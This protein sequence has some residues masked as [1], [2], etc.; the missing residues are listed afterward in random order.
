MILEIRE[1]QERV[2]SELPLLVSELQVVTG[3]FGDEEKDAWRNSLPLLAKALSSPGFAN[4][5]LYFNGSGALSLEYQLPAASSWCDVVLLGKKAGK[6]GA[7]IIELKHWITHSD[8]PGQVEGLVQH[9]GQPTLHPSDQVRGY[10]EYC[11]RFHSAIHDFEA[12][13]GGCVLFTKDTI[14][15]AYNEQPNEKLVAQFPCFTLSKE[16]LSTPFPEFIA[17]V[18]DEPDPNFAAAFETGTYKQDRGFVRQ[19]GEQIL[20]PQSS[21][22]ELLDNQRRAFALCQAQVHSSVFAPSKGNAKKVVVIEGPPG[23]GKSVVAAKIW[24]SLATNELLPEGSIVFTSTSASQNSNWAHLFNGTA[25]TVAGQGVVKKATSYTPI[26]T[27]ELDRLRKRYAD[28]ELFKDGAA[29]RDHLATLRNLGVRFAEG[30][31]D[32]EYLV[33]VVDEA[34]A[35]INPEHPEGRGQY[36]F[37]TGLGPQAYH[38]MRTSRISIFLLDGEQSFRTQENTTMGDLKQWAKELDADYSHVSLAGSQFRCAGSKEYVDWLEA[39]LEGQNPEICRVLSSAWYRVERHPVAVQ[40]TNVVEFPGSGS[41]WSATSR[42]AEDPP[43][44]KISPKKKPPTGLDFRIFETPQRMEDELRLRMAERFSA[45]LLSPYARPWKTKEAANPHDLPPSLKDFAI[46]YVDGGQKHIW[47]RVWNFI[48]SQGSDYATYIQGR[49]G[50]RIHADPLCEV[51]CPYA[52]RGF[53]WDY[54]GLLWLSDLVFRE[55]LGLVADPKNSHESGISRLRSKALK[56]S[57]PHGPIHFDLKKAVAQ[58]YR[59]LMTRPVRGIYVWF[60]DKETEEFVR[61]C[62]STVEFPS[63]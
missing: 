51:G 29:W 37:V 19:I 34:H 42:V 61:S 57:D 20:D 2:K 25:Q 62:L 52:V 45:R 11:R 35:L 31:R 8:A 26:S 15:R 30:S 33:S 39:V 17:K 36:G 46:P 40:A 63:K 21:P 60:E 38:I 48:P 18:V 13:V 16:D 10:V 4:L 27:H 47:S 1:F 12:D 22:F 53:D 14:T 9:L 59:I 50:S 3:R 5:H 6:P 24:A 43:E 28:S 7:V 41:K 32:N 49:E 54:V 44:Y 56:E 23:S 58:Y 55:G